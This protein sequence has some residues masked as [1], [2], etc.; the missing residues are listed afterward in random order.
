[1]AAPYA[2]QNLRDL[3]IRG[4]GFKDQFDAGLMNPIA[5]E[6]QDTVTGDNPTKEY[7]AKDPPKGDLGSFGRH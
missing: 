2:N 6:T 3:E 1:M 5:R 4:D 7:I